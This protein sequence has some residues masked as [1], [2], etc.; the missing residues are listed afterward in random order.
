MSSFDDFLGRVPIARQLGFRAARAGDGEA[1]LAMTVRQDLLQI[2]DRVH[3]GVLATLADTTAVWLLV[4]QLPPDA[5][6][7]SIEFKLNFLRPATV[8]RG[9]VRAVARV[10]KRGRRVAVCDV[11]V[12]QGDGAL[13]DGKQRDVLVAK[14]L[15]TY[16][17]GEAH[18]EAHGESLGERNG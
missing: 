3:G 5:M 4:T 18:G 2:E 12:M 10:V 1:A 13:R 16:L 9:D 6:F 14:G 15:F 7:T 8:G 17:M 11:D